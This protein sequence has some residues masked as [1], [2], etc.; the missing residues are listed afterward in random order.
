[1]PL[2]RA[3]CLTRYVH[4]NVGMLRAQCRQMFGGD[5]TAV[6]AG[7]RRTKQL[8]CTLLIYMRTSSYEP[9]N[10]STAAFEHLFFALLTKELL[11]D[12]TSTNNT[13][14]VPTLPLTVPLPSR[15]LEKSS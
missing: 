15:S 3:P 6:D 9:K 11:R 12:T 13:Q 5:I 14:C 1:M 7:E 10:L 8:I 4:V 2:H